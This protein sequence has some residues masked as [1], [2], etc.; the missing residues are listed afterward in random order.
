M[1]STQAQ[2]DRA[3]RRIF[4]AGLAFALV[5]SV[6]FSAKAVVI[7]L[8]YRY[9]VDAVT[10]LALR[11]LFAAPFF[12]AALAWSGRGRA[13]LTP[14]EH[15]RLVLMGLVG[16]YGAS[17]FDFLG[18]QHV[19]AGLERL[20]LYLYPTIVVVMSVLFLRRRFTRN[21]GIAM[22]VAYAGIL[23]AFWHDLETGG[24]DVPLG[25]ALIFGSALTY[26]LYLVLG[27]EM[28]HRIGAIRLTSY[29]ILVSTMAV[30]LQF[31]LVNSPSALAQPAPVYWLSAVNGFFCTVLPAFATML[32]I[33]R[34]GA[35]RTAL[36][37]MVGPVATIVLAAWLLDEHMSGWG[38]L[39]TALVLAGVLILSRARGR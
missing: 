17:Y 10:L 5:G 36:V 18:L 32:A 24:D 39:G 19:S 34:I 3:R 26:A 13:P 25:A 28:V 33:E 2:A 8:A 11:M 20:I 1:V 7:K 27:G 14:R 29:A 9:G 6:L 4:L 35:S 23:A 38:L 21:D 22:A 16:Y 12:A 31:L 15:A 30:A 37:A